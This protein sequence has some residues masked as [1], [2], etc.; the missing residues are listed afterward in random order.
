LQLISSNTPATESPTTNV[1]TVRRELQHSPVEQITV[2]YFDDAERVCGTLL[3]GT[4]SRSHVAAD[5]RI[6]LR[7]A[8]SSAAT[9]M[10][11]LHNHPSGS[12]IPSS[13]DETMTVELRRAGKA[14]GIELTEHLIVVPSGETRSI[15]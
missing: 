13:E 3:A 9:K 7:K 10:L 8:L 14:A 11:V 5:I 6:I 2:V 4:G 15:G 1:S 12:L